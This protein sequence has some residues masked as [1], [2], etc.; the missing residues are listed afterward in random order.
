MR[1]GLLSARMC[2]HLCRG[3]SIRRAKFAI[4]PSPA[5]PPSA[6]VNSGP[7]RVVEVLCKRFKAFRAEEGRQS[8]IVLRLLIL[9]FD[10]VEPLKV[11][12]QRGTQLRG[13]VAL[14]QHGIAVRASGVPARRQRSGIPNVSARYGTVG[15]RA[16]SCSISPTN[17][18][19][20]WRKWK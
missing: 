3:E 9:C 13:A 1:W 17:R 8:A 14:A 7:I 18:D 20:A 2:T 6:H 5:H 15:H 10:K 16:G 11:R 19:H 4:R 12:H